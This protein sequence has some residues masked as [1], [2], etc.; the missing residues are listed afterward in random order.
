MV[1]HCISWV[2]L[3]VF[4]IFGTSPPPYIAMKSEGGT[5]LPRPGPCRY[6]SFS[7][8]AQDDTTFRLLTGTRSDDHAIGVIDSTGMYSIW[9][10]LSFVPI[11]F[12]LTV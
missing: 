7:A 3:V 11:Q 6:L 8:K 4:V 10:Q 9:P 5:S 2:V 12:A 1:M